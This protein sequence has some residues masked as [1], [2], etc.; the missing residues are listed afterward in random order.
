MKS[1]LLLVSVLLS[2]AVLAGCA[3]SGK[4][5][6]TD[7]V[8]SGDTS[9]LN[10]S[11]NA[12]YESPIGRPIDVEPSGPDI[13]QNIILF[14]FDSAQIKP[15]YQSVIANHAKYLTANPNTRV[16]LEG[17]TDERGTREYNVGLG[18]RRASS[19]AQALEL[20]GVSPQQISIVS[21]GEERP[22]ALGHDESAWSQNRRVEILYP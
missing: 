5:S 2:A 18:E 11:G 10:T 8:E 1:K 21:Y 4:K 3:S 15:Q 7:A 6:S 12:G 14:D 19:V 17:H 13:S 20:R 16:R 22:V 9:G